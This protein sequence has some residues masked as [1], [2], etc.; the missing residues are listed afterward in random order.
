M[1]FFILESKFKIKLYEP[2]HC[3]HA[4]GALWIT[5]SRKEEF[6]WT[7]L[8]LRENSKIK[9]TIFLPPSILSTTMSLKGLRRRLIQNTI[10]HTKYSW[11][12]I[13]PTYTCLLVLCDVQHVNRWSDDAV[14]FIYRRGQQIVE[15]YYC[16][17]T[18]KIGF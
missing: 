11:S 15:T 8:V 17:T 6:V 1:Q 12:V 13:K 14:A 5:A 2:L 3:E 10:K 7:R 16:K 18:I 9:Y 4:Y